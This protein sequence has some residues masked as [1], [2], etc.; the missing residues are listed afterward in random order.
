MSAT[1]EQL[2]AIKARGEVLVS[3]SAGAGKTTV[4]IKRLADI[5]EEG[6]SLDN[7]LAV[8][9][10]KKAAAQM[11]EKLRRELIDRLNGGDETKRENIRLQL[12]KINSADISTIHSFCARLVRTYF[13]V[14]KVDA[15]FEV[16]A[17]GAE[18]SSLRARAMDDLFDGLYNSHDA[19]LYILLDK[20]RKKRSDKALK[21]LLYSAYDEVRQRPRWEELLDNAC[22]NTFTDEGF[23]KV[24]REYGKTLSDKCAVLLSAIED[25]EK[26]FHPAVNADGYFKVLAEM[27][28]TLAEIT[29]GCNPYEMPSKL[30]TAV[31]PRVKPEVSE[32]DDEFSRFV[33]GVK[34]R[35]KS[36]IKDVESEETERA[37]FLESGAVANAFCSVLLRFAEAYDGVKREEGK[38]DYGDLEHF[39]LNLLSGEECDGDVR[40]GIREK[41]KYVF[42]DEYQDVNPI[43]DEIISA[44]A[45]GDIFCVG[46]LKQAIYGFRGSRSRFFRDKSAK[47]GERGE[48]IVLPDNFRS[49]EG[50]IDFVNA[51]FSDIMR[52]PVCEFD[53]SEGHAMRGGARY[54]GNRGKAEICLFGGGESEKR[55]PLGIYSVTAEKA[56]ARQNTAEGLAVLTL[57]EE[58][59]KSGYFDADSGEFKKVQAGDI[60]VLTRKRA[61]K[62]AAGIIKA[63]SEKY[64]VAGAAETNICDR[65]EI[66]RLLDILSYLDNGEQDVPL[67][68]SLLSPLGNLNEGELAAVRIFADGKRKSDEKR[69]RFCECCRLY[70]EKRDDITAQKLRAF[71]ALVERLRTTSGSI[72]AA[73][74]IDEIM[75]VA[76]FSSAFDTEQKVIALRRLQRE[77]AGPSGELY[78]GAFLAK[79]KA[80]GNKVTASS[81]LSSDCVKVMTMHASKG[82]EFPVVIVADIAA[83]FGGDERADMLF[84]DEF[85]FAPRCYSGDRSMRTTVLRRL[86]KVRKEREE[87]SNEINLFYVACTRAKYALHVL[88]SSA[89]SYD[90]I[91]AAF[92]LNYADL[93]D[94]NSFT[95]RILPIERQNG[96]NSG[97]VKRVLDTSRADENF[98]RELREV[99]DFSYP[100]ERGV[101][102]PVKSSASQV[103]AL[104]GEETA[105]EILFDEEF[106]SGAGTSVDAG[107]AY[108]R[109][110]ELCDFKIRDLAGVES[111]LERFV[112]AGLMTENQRAL[113]SAERLVNIL[114]MPVFSGIENSSVFR[115]R[116]FVC[117]LP[118]ADYLAIKAGG[119]SAGACA[120]D[121]NSVICQ[122]AID[123]LHVRR[124]GGKI[125]SAH[126]IDYKYTSHGDDYLRAHYLPQLALYKNVV[127]KIYGLPESAVSAT[128]VNIYACR[129]VEIF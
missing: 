62:S 12:S 8:T 2:K 23:E 27:R 10:T 11:K 110:L 77:A 81:A 109:F 79:I 40:D 25:F 47:V 65:P 53:Y 74:L 88:T 39:A 104:L 49:G 89:E 38:L 120:D 50:V 107:I 24:S 99:T 15:S 17:D 58:A 34:K 30:C 1:P 108:H 42:V 71:Y 3:A 45:G 19:D 124:E 93:F 96:G 94:I 125:V 100:F 29:S 46:D 32:E 37:R 119:V 72:G 20:L 4:M 118:S 64:P 123:L 60:C 43:Q 14:L 87:L 51:L 90:K 122:G 56:A 112:T 69:L 76:G 83:D 106:V 63:L 70:A 13:Y 111:Q 21:E 7:V 66:R 68:T 75:R 41:Y 97:E 121:G 102:L 84:D 22:R 129:T 54:Q 85:G 80:G 116:E 117:R 35:Y 86:Y 6:A 105:G 57:V 61:N 44:V 55:E 91:K 31:K 92:A 52:P 113:I 78:L 82:L 128:I 18:Q 95:P 48:Y 67:V 114:K 126:I 73:R 115:E 26:D 59:L 36:L 9:F 16:L 98:A 28:E 5:L 103:L 127:G 33:D 101:E